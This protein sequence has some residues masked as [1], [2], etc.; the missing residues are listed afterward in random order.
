M[1]QR[2]LSVAI[3]GA[4]MGGLTAAATLRRVGIDV[5][6]YEQAQKFTRLGAGI[7]QSPNAVKVLRQLGLESRLR[8]LSFQPELTRY[9]E[10]ATG[11]LLWEK[12]QGGAFEDRYGAPHFLLHRGDL[13]EALLSLVPQSIILPGKNLVSYS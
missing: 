8:E 10:A 2:T 13:H 5:K 6:I 3:I 11:K 12:T 9:R 1:S 4:G 7:Q